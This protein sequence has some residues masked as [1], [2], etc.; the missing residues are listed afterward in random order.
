MFWRG[1][2][3]AL[4][5]GNYYEKVLLQNIFEICASNFPLEQLLKNIFDDKSI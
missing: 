2:F 5:K 1:R 3:I 4:L